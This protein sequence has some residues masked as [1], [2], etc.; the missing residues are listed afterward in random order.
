VD[1]LY[2]VRGTPVSIF[3][4]RKGLIRS[5]VEGE[6]DQAQLQRQ[7]TELTL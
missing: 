5:I 4:D 1:E 6:M 7:V 3:I 2:L